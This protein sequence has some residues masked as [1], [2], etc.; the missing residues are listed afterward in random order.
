MKVWRG[1]RGA[2]R[3]VA[4][5][6]AALFGISFLPPDTSLRDRQAVGSLRYCVADLQSALITNPEDGTAGT[7]RQL[8]AATADALGLRLVVIEVPNMKRSF[9]PADWNVTRGQC[10]V[11]GGGLADNAVNRGFLTLLPT[12]QRTGL[13]LFN[14]A[15]LPPPSSQLGIYLGSEGFDRIKLSGWIR[16][17]GWRATPLRDEA[18]LRAWAK[19]GNPLIAPRSTIAL[20]NMSQV[21]LPDGAAQN[22]RLA[23]GLWRGDMTLTRA[24]SRIFN[25]FVIYDLPS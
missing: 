6:A 24:I 13:A 19:G 11:L 3:D 5:I 4:V 17:Q 16:A 14:A 20:D 7:E 25:D 10:D 1:W 2:L 8:M 12:G 21:E 9:N 15:D 23:I 18:A 22:S